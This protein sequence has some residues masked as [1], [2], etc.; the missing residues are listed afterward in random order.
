MLGLGN[1]QRLTFRTAVG[2]VG[3]AHAGA[4]FDAIE[5][6]S[7]A[8]EYP[9]GAETGNDDNEVTLIVHRQPRAGKYQDVKVYAESESAAPLTAPDSVVNVGGFF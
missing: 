4:R 1:V 2:C 6:F 3:R 8:A 7:N 9:R 5:R